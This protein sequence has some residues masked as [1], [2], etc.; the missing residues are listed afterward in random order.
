MS[1]Q[2]PHESS[3]SNDSDEQPTGIVCLCGT[4]L[5]LWFYRSP[6]T[7]RADDLDNRPLS[8]MALGMVRTLSEVDV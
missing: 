5:Y 3:E 7:S 2:P 4:P 1:S 6:A 8:T